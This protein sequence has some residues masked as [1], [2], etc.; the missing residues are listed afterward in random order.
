M[1][2]GDFLKDENNLKLQT[3]AFVELVKIAIGT[4]TGEFDFSSL[5]EEDWTAVVKESQAHAVALLTFS[6]TK[7]IK[8]VIPKSVYESW[9]RTAIMIMS[10]N[11]VFVNAQNELDRLMNENGINYVVLKGIASGYYYPD[12]SMRPSGDIDFLTAERDFPKVKQ[13]LINAG[14]E[15]EKEDHDLHTVF[16]KGRVDLELHK[17]PAGMPEGMQ[18]EMAAEFLKDIAINVVREEKPKFSRPCDENH[19]LV[20]LFHTIYHLFAGGMGIRHLCDWA[21]FVNKSHKNPVWQEKLLPFFEKIGLLRFVMTLTQSCIDHLNIETPVW[22]VNGKKELSDEIF[23]KVLSGGNFG[24]KNTNRLKH[25]SFVGNGEKQS[26]L[27]KL[28][29]MVTIL[30]KTCDTMYPFLKK[31]PVLHPFVFL[32]RIIKYIFLLML[33]KKTSIKQRMQYSD[34][35]AAIFDRFEIYR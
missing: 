12:Y 18:G 13:M 22:F 1:I 33:G 29:S 25:Y 20:I 16:K 8:N 32:W 34:E 30:W 9:F 27:S 17:K 26:N 7:S 24:R 11:E 35:R 4:S 2:L 19:A 28:K 10:A 5:T 3:D 23:I 31:A 15:M 21:C 14:Y 6:A